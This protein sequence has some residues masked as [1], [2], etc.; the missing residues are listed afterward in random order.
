M[1]THETK[2]GW[3]E[4]RVN[5]LKHMWAAGDSCQVIADE[6]GGITRCAVIGKVHRLGLAE[7]ETKHAVSGRWQG[8][9]PKRIR[10][11]KPKTTMRISKKNGSEPILIDEVMIDMI[12]EE[13][14]NIP[15][16]QRKKLLQLTAKTCHF[17]VGDPREEG[18]FF[19]GA[20]PLEDQP[21]CGRHCSVAF[22]PHASRGGD[23][24]LRKWK[25]TSKSGW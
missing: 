8:H 6:L 11:A 13:D 17:P 7:R 12:L 5:I 21:Y 9:Q 22:M 23:L 25:T 3:T 20:E 1:Y 16:E 4:E 15:L 19:C 24:S 18:F 2:A 14:K 10:T